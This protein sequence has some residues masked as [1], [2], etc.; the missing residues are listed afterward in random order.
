MDFFNR[1]LL[2][3]KKKKSFLD[4]IVF[5][6][7]DNSFGLLSALHHHASAPTLQLE[8]FISLIK[9]SVR[10][11]SKFYLSKKKN[12]FDQDKPVG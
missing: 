4:D 8:V 1:R 11:L 9:I 3:K 5:V 10:V 12:L 2:P 7:N 6:R